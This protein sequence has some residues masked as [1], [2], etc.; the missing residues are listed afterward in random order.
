MELAAQILGMIFVGVIIICIGWTVLSYI[1]GSIESPGKR[2]KKLLD[3]MDKLER[4]IR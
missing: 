3:N 1:L 4:K 2:N